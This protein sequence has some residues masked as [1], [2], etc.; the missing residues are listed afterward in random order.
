MKLSNFYFTY[1]T[2]EYYPFYGGWTKIAAPSKNIALD[3]FVAIHPNN[4]NCLNCACYYTEDEFKRT[5]MYENGNLGAREHEYIIIAK[6]GI[7]S[8]NNEIEM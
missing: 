1:G 2:D 5:S 8:K 7:N 3:Y 4:G 6:N